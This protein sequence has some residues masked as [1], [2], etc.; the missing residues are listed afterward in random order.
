VFFEDVSTT[1][2]FVKADR[3]AIETLLLSLLDN[4]VKYTASG[5]QVFLRSRQ[6]DGCA[7]I[8]V[9]DTGIGIG[10]L[11]CRKYSTGS[12]ARIKLAR[13]RSAVQVSACRLRNGSLKFTTARLK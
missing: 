6:E 3:T 1:P 4:A 7:L 11:I 12:S 13:E 9:Q 2:M 10:T 8:E 5:D